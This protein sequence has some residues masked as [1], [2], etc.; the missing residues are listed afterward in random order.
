MRA[1]IQ[2]ESAKRG[3]IP[4]S[5]VE[6]KPARQPRQTV[7]EHALKLMRAGIMQGRYAPGQRLVEADLMHELGISRGP[8]REVLRRLLADGLVTIEP[9]RGAEV[10]RLTRDG[11]ESAF[12]VRELLEGLAA[13]QAAERFA[14]G[15]LDRK[16]VE[17]TLRDYAGSGSGNKNEY[18][19]RNVRF[20]DYIATLS[21]NS[22]VPGILTRIQVPALR[23]HFPGLLVPADFVASTKEHLEIVSA[24]CAGDGDGAEKAMRTHVRRT[25]RL[26]RQL[27]DYLFPHALSRTR[28]AG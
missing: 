3:E 15:A 18:M 22:H 12:D 11:L 5:V 19:E 28:K 27:P 13:R 24:I 1:K 20:H 17:K 25:A 9:Y 26:A 2:H 7:V 23:S 8:I 6:G 14:R 10:T 16:A 4:P 21:G